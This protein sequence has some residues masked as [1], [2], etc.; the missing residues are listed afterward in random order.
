MSS[1]EAIHHVYHSKPQL[2]HRNIFRA[3]NRTFIN[4]DKHNRSEIR[5]IRKSSC[6]HIS[7]FTGEQNKVAKQEYDCIKTKATHIIPAWMC[8][9]DS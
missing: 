7:A 3:P 1:S 8:F 2:S 9:T 4:S 6:Y 5:C